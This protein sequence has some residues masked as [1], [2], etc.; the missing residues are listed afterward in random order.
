MRR[1]VTLLKLEEGES[2]KPAREEVINIASYEDSN[3]KP[4]LSASADPK[5][6]R[7]IE[8]G[9]DVVVGMILGGKVDRVGDF[10]FATIE[11]RIIPKLSEKP[12]RHGTV[13]D[14]FGDQRRRN[15]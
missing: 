10:G 8:V 4:Q 5:R 11:D 15:A 12:A 7:I 6:Y 3:K 13:S 2:L 1:F 14:G 9:D